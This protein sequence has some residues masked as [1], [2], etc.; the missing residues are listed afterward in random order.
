M[1]HR[2]SSRRRHHSSCHKPHACTKGEKKPEDEHGERTT[3]HTFNCQF[4]IQRLLAKFRDSLLGNHEYHRLRISQHRRDKTLGRSNRDAQIDIIA[5]DDPSPSRLAFA[6][7][8][9]LSAN[10]DARANTDVK[11]SLMLCSSRMWSSNLAPHLYSQ[12]M[13]ISLK[14]VSDATVCFDSFRH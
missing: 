1:A 13:S 12:D 5:I 7:G 4:A 9:S 3:R 10:R 14:V 6:A 8:I 2:T 11:S